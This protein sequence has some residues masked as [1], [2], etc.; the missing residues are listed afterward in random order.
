[1]SSLTRERQL[2]RENGIK[3]WVDI[4]DFNKKM[5]WSCGKEIYSK[6]FM[7][8]ES[9][10]K[11]D[12]YPNGNSPE[13]VG[14]VSVYLNNDSSWKVKSRVTFSVKRHKR[15][16]AG[17]IEKGQSSGIPKFVSHVEMEKKNL[18]NDD[19]GLTL[20]VDVELLEEE[21]TA[22]RPTVRDR[23]GIIEREVVTITE[24]L[25]SQKTEIRNMNR[26]MSWKLNQLYEMLKKL[27]A[28]SDP[29]LESPSA[30]VS[31]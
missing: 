10:F 20:E 15:A 11:I 17:Y 7:I 22:L 24:E 27:A 18:L 13:E 1:M 6:G 12:I 26:E 3:Y 19:N 4:C 30:T 8:G 29:I 28:K 9:V 31:A 25:E 23:V 2:K 5:N 21:V 14:Y 16:F